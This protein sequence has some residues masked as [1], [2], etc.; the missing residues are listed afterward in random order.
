[1]KLKDLIE[2]CKQ[3][4]VNENSEIVIEIWEGWQAKI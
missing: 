2:Y 4:N 1:M 3:N